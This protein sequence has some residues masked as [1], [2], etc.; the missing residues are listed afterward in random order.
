MSQQQ[1]VPSNDPSP[2]LSL[3]VSTMGRENKQGGIIIPAHP[4]LSLTL[5]CQDQGHCYSLV[6]APKYT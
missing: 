1:T 4:Q 5:P 3:H 6:I 2:F